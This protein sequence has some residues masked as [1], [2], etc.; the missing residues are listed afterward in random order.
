M[1]NIFRT[2]PCQRLLRDGICEWRS[3]CQFSH[4]LEW[5]R[6][7]PQKH[8]YAPEL[9]P[10]LR[11]VPSAGPGEERGRVQNFCSAGV[12]CPCAHS[13]EEV[14]YH[15]QLFK[16]CMCE[17]HCGS[18]GGGQR[19]ARGSARG[20]R[21][22][23]Y[24]CPFA[25]GHQELRSSHL[26]AEQR[27]RCL[28]ALELFPAGEC[29][30]VCAPHRLPPQVGREAQVHDEGAFGCPQSPPPP[31]PQRQQ[32]QQQQQQLSAQEVWAVPTGLSGHSQLPDSQADGR[33]SPP[34]KD[35]YCSQQQQQHGCE[36]AQGPHVVAFRPWGGM[37][38]LAGFSS[39][40][41]ADCCLG[42]LPPQELQQ[43]AQ[44]VI[45]LAAMAPAS[46]LGQ[47]PLQMLQM[48]SMAGPC[49]C[50]GGAGCGCGLAGP[51]AANGAGQLQV[52]QVTPVGTP[53]PLG[54]S[55]SAGSPLP[56]EHGGG[57]GATSPRENVRV[58][59]ANAGVEWRSDSILH[60]GFCSPEA[61]ATASSEELERLG[62]G[63]AE[64]LRLRQALEEWRAG[65]GEVGAGG[66]GVCVV[67]MGNVRP[68]MPM[69]AVVLNAPYASWFTAGS[70]VGSGFQGIGV[71]WPQAQQTGAMLTQVQQPDVQAAVF[72]PSVA[73]Q[74]Q[75]QPEQVLHAPQPLHPQPPFLLGQA[76]QAP[77]QWSAS[78]G[79][80]ATPPPQAPQRRQRPGGKGDGN[81]RPPGGNES[82]RSSPSLQEP[83]ASP[84]KAAASGKRR[85]AK[86]ANENR[87]LLRLA[88][89]LLQAADPPVL[90]AAELRRRILVEQGPGD[91]AAL[92]G[93]LH[94]QLKAL[95][96]KFLIVGS[97][98]TLTKFAHLPKVKQALDQA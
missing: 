16:T 36:A 39:P 61:L 41:A 48:T 44:Q 95:P 3:Q 10:H 51:V 47:G 45:Q 13:K 46:A 90:P 67:P 93:R 32:R 11:A 89:R 74:Q 57:S 71:P 80:P 69:Q 17:E 37:N 85:N 18:S 65:V 24:Y 55:S 76:A 64:Q 15:P 59:L 38:E 12:R 20:R 33:S 81:E 31:P 56:L 43:A 19:G 22:H 87:G 2:K 26:S 58:L 92:L 94:Q 60:A 30:L 72:L 42:P 70:A 98:V 14:L 96:E 35:P 49:A 53:P 52:V 21:C 8:R 78:A 63:P 73:A 29:C 50:A 7:P 82:A 6:R 91:G 1:L 97:Q 5:P 4:S 54:R 27:E 25:H 34:L 66:G 75:A 62:L 28:R 88:E 9:C 83:L 86:Q 68:G 23:R 77:M 40:A 79:S 84:L